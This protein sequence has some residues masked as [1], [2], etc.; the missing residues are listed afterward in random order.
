M[1]EICDARSGALM[2]QKGGAEFKGS[3]LR[4]SFGGFDGFGNSPE[5]LA[6][7]S[8]ILQNEGR[9]GNREGFDSFGGHGGFGRDNYPP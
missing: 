5:H 4:D 1:H 3:S 8:I 7:L 6:L 2:R 9:R